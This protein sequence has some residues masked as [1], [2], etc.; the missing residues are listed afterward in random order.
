ME[1]I[2]V[3]LVI[4][5]VAFVVSL[6]VAMVTGMWLQR[7]RRKYSKPFVTKEMVRR[8][9]KQVMAKAPYKLE[10]PEMGTKAW[11]EQPGEIVPMPMSDSDLPESAVSWRNL[12]G[13]E[14]ASPLPSTSPPTRP[15]PTISIRPLAPC[16]RCWPAAADRW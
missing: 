12:L 15:T 5:A 4:G 7:Q 11:R 6:L 1:T 8:A 3:A 13:D 16:G 9:A 2:L 10:P 14:A